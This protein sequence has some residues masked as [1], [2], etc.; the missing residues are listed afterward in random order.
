MSYSTPESKDSLSFIDD[1]ALFDEVKKSAQMSNKQNG[2]AS[3]PNSS[4]VPT[5]SSST[6]TR[7][8]MKDDGKCFTSGGNTAV[9]INNNNSFGLSNNGKI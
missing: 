8:S 1:D 4:L 6:S 3:P 9:N 5:A 7:K 2:W